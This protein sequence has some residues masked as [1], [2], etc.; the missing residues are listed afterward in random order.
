MGSLAAAP[1]GP[2]MRVPPGP[3]A[4]REGLVQ[5]HTTPFPRGPG[6]HSPPRAQGLGLSLLRPLLCTGPKQP[7]PLPCHC[8]WRGAGGH[9][10]IPSQL[11]RGRKVR[12]ESLGDDNRLPSPHGPG[13][14]ALRAVVF[15]S[16]NP[17]GSAFSSSPVGQ[18]RPGWAARTSWVA[19]S[20]W[21]SSL[22]P[23]V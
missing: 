13:V 2:C 21:G 7:S 16:P 23:F 1:E 14:P 6:V 22:R 4:E 18:G 11:G 10:G 19:G 20:E 8:I 5:G 17:M 15:L 3:W 9:T 12:R